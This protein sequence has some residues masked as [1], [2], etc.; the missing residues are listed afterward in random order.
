MLG[1]GL[2]LIIAFCIWSA[3]SRIRL[4]QGPANMSIW[5]PLQYLSTGT[6]WWF[7]L[8]HDLANIGVFLPRQLSVFELIIICIIM[9]AALGLIFRESGG[10]VH[11]FV[12]KG[13]RSM[14]IRVATMIDAIYAILLFVFKE[15]SNI[16]MS[17]TWVFIGLMA[18]R[19]IG[20]VVWHLNEGK[21]GK[22]LMKKAIRS[23][24]VRLGMISF[25]A[26]VSL[27]LVVLVMQLK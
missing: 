1:Y 21:P 17:T 15:W 26:V 6:L 7:W 16:P 25:G 4:K 23:V 22:K 3:L 10:N 5:R 2:A 27:M 12:F 24:A 14:D 18:G 13:E 11:K 20:R 9:V 19:E 8:T